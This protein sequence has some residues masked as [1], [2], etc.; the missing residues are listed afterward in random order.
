MSSLPKIIAPL[1]PD[2]QPASLF[3]RHYL[4]AAKKSGQAIPLVIGLE[5]EGSFISRYETMVKSEADPDTLRYVERI[6]KNLLW[7][8]GGWKIYFG[9]P[10]QTGEYI[11]HCYSADG[12]RKFDVE[13]MSRVYERPFEVVVTK[14][15]SVPVETEIERASCRE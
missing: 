11:R 15:E 9:G 12:E 8:R 2:F 13:L 14:A 10:R 5:R 4:A 6:V 1:D 7:V 3:N